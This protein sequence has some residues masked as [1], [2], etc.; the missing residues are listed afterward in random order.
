MTTTDTVSQG[1]R[2]AG[3]VSL[4]ALGGLGP[5]TA[6][7]FAEVA[8]QAWR[9]R[10]R[11]LE[12]TIDNGGG[13]LS[14]A[15]SS[16]EIFATLYSVLMN[17]GAVEGGHQ[18]VA[19][20]GTPGEDGAARTMGARF[21]GAQDD[22]HDR[23]LMS[24]AHY[25]LVL[26]AALI[27][28]GRLEPE[29]LKGFNQDGSTVEMIGAEHS[30]GM[31]ATTGSLGQALAVAVGRALARRRRGATGRIWVLLSDGELQEG[32]TWESLAAASAYEL[33]NLAVLVEANGSQC[34]GPIASVLGVEPIAEKIASFGWDVR[35]VDGH[36][37][38]AIWSAAASMLGGQSGKAR[39]KA[40]ICRT[41][42]W[43]DMPSLKSHSPKYHYI[44]LT[45]DE[46]L[47]AR[48]DLARAEP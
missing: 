1:A 48:A 17:L 31:E 14:Q 46:A 8:E 37:A 25:A 13:Y 23:F 39:P 19:F 28:V 41:S 33:S 45:P 40:I 30:P 15:C 5:P 9:I 42:C 20:A 34:D 27:E 3:S 6:E 10:R 29:S 36:D 44:R 26:Y 4:P 22:V 43:R 35:E 21:N 2:Q 18:A 38:P 32:E 7:R 11:V 12:H 47:A 16:A 24:P